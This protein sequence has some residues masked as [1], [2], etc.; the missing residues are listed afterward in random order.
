[1]MN[2]DVEGSHACQSRALPVMPAG[3]ESWTVLDLTV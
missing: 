1:M 2:V 3:F